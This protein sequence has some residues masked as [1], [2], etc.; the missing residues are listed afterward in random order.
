MNPNSSST[1]FDLVIRHGTA[2]TATEFAPCDI[3]IKDGRIH[4]LGLGLAPGAQEIDARHLWVLPGGVETH[5]H[6]EQRSAAGLMGADNFTSGSIAAAFGGHT[7]IVPFAAQHKG[8]GLVEVVTDYSQRAVRSVLDYAF[9][10]IITDPTPQVM[11]EELP[12][13]IRQGHT[14][15]KV[16]L[17]YDRLKIDD[18]QMLAILATARREGAL[19][20]VHAENHGMIQWLSQ[21]LLAAGHREPRYHAMAH[22]RLSEVEAVQRAIKL[23]ELT[24]APLFIVHVSTAEA[25]A[26]V[27]TAQDRGQTV[28]AETCPQYLLLTAADLDR[29]GLEGAKWLCSPPPRDEA[30]QAALWRGLKNGT[31]A[32]CTSD[33]APYRFDA[34]G[35]L[36]KGDD[37]S[38]AEIPSGIPGIELR[39]PLLF[40]EGV[41][42]GRLDPRAFAAL[43]ATNPARIF[44]LQPRKGGLFVGGDADLALWDPKRQVRVT[45]ELLHDRTGYTPY[46]GRILTGWPVTVI[47]RGEVV[48]RDGALLAK[49]GG[50]QWLHRAPGSVAPSG[51]LVPE[52]DPASNFNADLL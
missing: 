43:S 31:L 19:V 38:F 7:T 29:P 36:A 30:T 51:Q 40:S 13:L 35:K 10:L 22:A 42:Q 5:C 24:D 45:P 52:L 18:A 16:F 15:L 11:A 23:A 48:V 1:A 26:V 17:T 32:T 14:S 28:F 25:M 37:P 6:I 2:V 47:R 27:R 8:Q 21:Q 3:G 34:E 4:G 12:A 41:S 46:Q 9:H 44:G 50:G 20:M 49:D 39:L 33:H